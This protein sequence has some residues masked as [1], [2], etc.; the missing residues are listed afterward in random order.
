MGLGNTS[1]QTKIRCAI[2]NSLNP[3]MYKNPDK[4]AKTMDNRIT[5]LLY[6]TTCQ[7]NSANKFI[8][9]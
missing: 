3:L 5:M 7:F 4:A 1:K 8:G 6:D 9:S 2:A